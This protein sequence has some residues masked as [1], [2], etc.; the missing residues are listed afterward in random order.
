MCTVVPT[1]LNFSYETTTSIGHFDGT[2]CFP[3]TRI[4]ARTRADCKRGRTQSE[5][6]VYLKDVH[7]PDAQ[8]SVARA[9]ELILRAAARGDENTSPEE[10]AT[11]LKKEKQQ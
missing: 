8:E 1:R 5:L 2:M 11:R 6:A 4:M 7:A 9:F 3:F 10:E